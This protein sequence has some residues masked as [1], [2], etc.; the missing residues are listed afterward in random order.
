[1]VAESENERG[2]KRDK[3]TGGVEGRGSWRERKE[4]ERQKDE[5]ESVGEMM[6]IKKRNGA[7]QSW[8]KLN[9]VECI[10]RDKRTLIPT[11]LK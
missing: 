8:T 6:G 3:G 4:R 5:D 1:M 10:V 7:G 2:K 9:I 11:K